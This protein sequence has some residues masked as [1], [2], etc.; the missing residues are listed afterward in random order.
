MG[1][2]RDRV[3][4]IAAIL[5]AANSGATKTRIMFNA[6]LSFMLLEKYLNLSVNA[7]FIR[8][9]GSTYKLTERGQ[10]YL[11]QYR[12]FKDRYLLAQELLEALDNEREKLSQSFKQSKILRTV[13]PAV[14]IE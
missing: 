2:N 7:C 5:E 4:I 10:E 6:N 1:K 13:E 3:S 12:L 14:E 8:V 11:K 9:E